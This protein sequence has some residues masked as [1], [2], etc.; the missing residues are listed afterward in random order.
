MWAGRGSYL[1]YERKIK[2]RQGVLQIG[3]ETETIFIR[4]SILSWCLRPFLLSGLLLR[5]GALSILFFF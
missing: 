1:E 5:R 4:V 2:G 3:L